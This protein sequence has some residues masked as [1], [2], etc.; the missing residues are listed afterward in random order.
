MFRTPGWAFYIAVILILA[1]LP[2]V[3]KLPLPDDALRVDRA[4]FT[5][6]S[7]G[8]T[9][10]TLPHRMHRKGEQAETGVYDVVVELEEVPLTPLYIFIPA[11]KRH[12]EIEQNGEIIFDSRIRQSWA[13]PANLTTGLALLP[14]ENLHSGANHLRLS[15]HGE[16][17]IP[18]YLSA[19]Y[20]GTQ[21]TLE[22]FFKLRVFVS[23]RLMAMAFSV[24]IILGVGLF[25]A[26]L[27]RTREKA[28]GWLA[29][30]VGLGTVFQ[31]NMFADIF[32]AILDYQPY[33]FVLFSSFGCLIVIFTLSLIDRP[34]PRFLIMA[35]VL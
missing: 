32:P 1:A 26:Y 30:L 13:G 7:G 5:A 9:R 8:T 21:E 22:P 27:Y 16:P 25:V 28:F 11:V 24:Q 10:V 12:L 3:A 23:E 4:L 15:L 6:E 14:R 29:I 34:P 19:L 2:Y 35:S 33:V 18:S 17:V 20:L 31:V